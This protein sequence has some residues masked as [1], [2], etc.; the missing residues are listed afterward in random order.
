MK[1]IGII[2]EYNPFHKG[3]EYQIHR[4]K[5]LFPEKKIIIIMS[6]D[7][8]QRGEPAVFSKHLRANC[9]LSCGAD[10]IFELPA[11][12]AFASA[13]YFAT[14]ALS[15]LYETGLVDT[16]CFGAEDEEPALFSGAADILLEEPDTYRN[17]LK[18]QL[19]NGCSY[20]LARSRALAA[21]LS[22]P[23]SAE[24][25]NRPN[26]IL[27]VEY[28]KAIKRFDYSIQTHIIKR[29]GAGYHDTDAADCY[30]SAAALRKELKNENCLPYS[31]IPEKARQ[32]LM[33]SPYS[34]PLFWEDFYP[35][36]QYALW[37]HPSCEDYFEMNSALSNRL[38]HLNLYPAD[39][40]KLIQ[41]LS[42]RHITRARIRRALLNLLLEEK[43][44]PASEEA[45]HLPYLRLLGFRE[46]ARPL[47]KKM[48]TSCS[49][50]VINKTADAKYILSDTALDRFEKDI[51][52]SLLYQQAFYNKYDIVL[53]TEYEQSVIIEK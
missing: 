23:N 26:N 43:P 50:P 25:L 46:S 27:A 3:H 18:E 35:F 11:P 4:I 34:R 28:I 1:H 14:A 12:F 7:Y 37:N 53:P 24:L 13:E 15:A 39:L 48:K 40:E 9:A 29:I 44:V 21:C 38:K 33:Q 22:C 16:L 19:G 41:E 20:P 8:V 45:R 31:H 5:E 2:A 52:N 36:L 47:L 17:I 51:H 30:P 42:G 49:L 32:V 6:G 10:I